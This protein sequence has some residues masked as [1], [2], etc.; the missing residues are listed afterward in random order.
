MNRN[1]GMLAMQL[2]NA[3]SDDSLATSDVHVNMDGVWHTL[4]AGTVV[5]L[6]PGESISLTP[7]IYHRFWAEEKRVL[8]GE[9]SDVNDDF[10]DNCFYQMIGTGRFSEVEEDA[11]PVRLLCNE[12]SNYWHPLD[13]QK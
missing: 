6:H 4:P 8:M 13:P 3:A 7:R 12:Y 2:Y 5:H 10:L 11:L 9:V 1:G